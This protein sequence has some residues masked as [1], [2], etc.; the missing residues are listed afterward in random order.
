MNILVTG[1]N[2]QLGREIATI[3]SYRLLLGEEQ[4]DKYIFTC[5]NKT[6]SFPENL[7]YRVLDIT[8]RLAVTKFIHDNYINVIVNCAAYTDV[9]A[10]EDNEAQAMAV[11]ADAVKY[12][13]EAGSKSGV[14]IIHI[15]TDYVYSGTRFLPI[16]EVTYP[17]PQNKYGESKLNGEI[18]LINSGCRHIIIRTQWLYSKYG[19]NNFPSKII[20]KLIN[21]ESQFPVVC[22]QIGCPTYAKDLANAIISIIDNNSKSQ[23]LS[24]CGIYNF[25]GRGAVSFY[26]VATYIAKKCFNENKIKS[27]YTFETNPKV[28]RP[29]YSVLDLT[30]FSETFGSEH[31]KCWADS[32]D[33]YIK[34]IQQKG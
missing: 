33:A 4:N 9:N 25:S 3:I 34:E 6:E 5:L 26:D 11:N 31:I 29:Y 28:K 7:D 19:K 10:A 13:A 12:L 18:N 20:D 16:K 8:D 30:K 2:G 15:S 17:L 27:I 23:T 21:G 22:D 32:M 24:K 1:S 14:V